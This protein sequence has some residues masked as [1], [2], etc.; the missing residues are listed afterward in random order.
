VIDPVLATG[1]P[2]GLLKLELLD[3]LRLAGSVPADVR[4]DDARALVTHPGGV[5]LPPAFTVGELADGQW[6]AVSPGTSPTPWRAR[7]RLASYLR[8]FGPWQLNLDE[9]QRQVY[10][11][12]AD[13]LEETGSNDLT[14]AGRTFRVV[15]V[16]RLIR[17]GPDGPEGPRA[18][19][20]DPQGPVLEG[21]AL[22]EDPVHEEEDEESGDPVEETEDYKRL[23]R[24]IR[25]E[26]KR[27][28]RP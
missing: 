7:K 16:E 10:A 12:A 19:D 21:L 5:L 2:D 24:L 28:N 15:R 26:E 17:I 22:D 1:L 20:P 13:W 11:A 18:S 23:E 9:E 8:I 4:A 27:R 3:S 14:V 6:G 25:E